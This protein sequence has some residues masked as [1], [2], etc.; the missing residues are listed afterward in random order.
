MGVSHQKGWVRL[1]GKKWYGYFRRTELDPA[2][3]N[4]KLNVAQVILGLKSEMSKYE[5][6]EKLEREIVRLGGQST[7]DQSVVNGAV[8]FEWFVNNRYLPLKETDWREETAKVKK[9]L[10]QA[11]LVDTFA[12][13]RL[14]NI[15]KFSLQTH[16]NRLAQ[17]RSRDR[18]LQVRAYLQ[19]I[20]AEA[21]DQDFIGKDPAR[22]I[23]VPAHLKETD[24]TVLSWDQL[25][26]VLSKLG[27]CDR[28]VLELEMTNALRPSE[29]FGLK[30]KCFD[31]ATSSIKIEETTYKGKIRPWG[32]TKGSLATIPIASDLAEELQ[33]WRIQCREEQR[34]KKHWQGPTADDPEGFIFPA[35]DG[36]FIDTGN[37]RRRVLHKFAKELGL[38][39]L[40]FQVIRRTVATL[41]RKKGDIKDVQGVL[42]HSRTATTTDVYMQELPEG[43]RA[44]VN[45]IHQ[46]LTQK[47]GGN[48]D[49]GPGTSKP[50]AKKAKVLSFGSRKPVR[51]IAQE[52][53]G[54]EAVFS[55]R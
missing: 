3:N 20:F 42:R 2:T 39:K 29:L 32:K 10:I 50:S 27:R 45:S 51:Q 44:T 4:S 26:A 49:R 52:R 16:L 6:R 38:P 23:K 9:H 1:R 14:E 22:T 24:K 46:E 36:G 28:I 18:V 30:W 41:A 13:A 37:Y 25:R 19:A 8:T 5:A 48:G 53:G 34:Q 40:T 11:D 55:G 17:T 31:P 12:D 7:G 54:S 35:R 43:V 33:A 21:V 47:G 15:D